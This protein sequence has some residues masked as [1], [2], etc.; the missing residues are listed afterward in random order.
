GY[1]HFR[2]VMGHEFVGRVVS[3]PARWRQK[4]VAVE[5]NCVCGRCDMCRSGMASHCRRRTVIGI[6]GRDGCFADLIA[7]P[8][9][10]CHLLPEVI[11]DEEAVFIEPL[12]AAYQVVR[13]VRIEPR[14]RVA[15]VGA[16]RL[17]LLVAQVL[18][19]TGCRLEVISRSPDKLGFCEKKGI[20]TTLVRD[21]VPKADRDVVVECSGASGGLELAMKLVRP[22]GT[23]VLKSTTTGDGQV[24]LAPLV[25]SEVTLL[26]SRCGPFPEAINALARK[27]IDV[28][29]MISKT[30]NLAKGLDALEAASDPR[31]IKVLLKS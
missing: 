12:A 14:T 5:I 25:I 21:L 30:Y 13:Q 24:N 1:M 10:N 3:G 4:R 27:Q 23:I 2:G 17:G 29:S 16:G 19:T 8:E 20:Q 9:R 28:L 22:R 26:G 18:A 11:S 7:V 31:N 15:V 6:D